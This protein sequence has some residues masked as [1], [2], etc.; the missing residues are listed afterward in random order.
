MGFPT[1]AAWSA[2][3]TTSRDTGMAGGPDPQ[4]QPLRNANNSPTAVSPGTGEQKGQPVNFTRSRPG[5]ASLHAEHLGAED[6]NAGRLG[7]ASLRAEHLGVEDIAEAGLKPCMRR[8]SGF[9]LP[10]I[11]GPLQIAI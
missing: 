6:S 5:S 1:V 9:R 8:G 11:R 2:P 4:S 3:A 7:A 10:G